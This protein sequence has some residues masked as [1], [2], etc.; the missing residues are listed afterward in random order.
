MLSELPPTDC[1]IGDERNV[2]EFGL[3][4]PSEDPRLIYQFWEKVPRAE[5]CATKTAVQS[6]GQLAGL[7]KKVNNERL[8]TVE[9][10]EEDDEDTQPAEA[11]R[12]KEAGK[13]G[14]RK[15][16]WL[17]R[18][19]GETIA[20]SEDDK[21][22]TTDQ[23]APSRKE[24]YKKEY[25]SAASGG[26]E[27][28]PMSKQSPKT[29]SPKLQSPQAPPPPDA[30]K[31][32]RPSAAKAPK[33]A[34]ERSHD[35]STP[36]GYDYQKKAKKDALPSTT[37]KEL[38]RSPVQL[39]PQHPPPARKAVL[40]SRHSPPRP[41]P[42]ARVVLTPNCRP[43]YPPPSRA[44]LR[45]ATPLWDRLRHELEALSET[46]RN[47][48]LIKFIKETCFN[49]TNCYRDR[50]GRKLKR[51]IPIPVKM[52]NLLETAQQ[53]RTSILQRYGYSDEAEIQETH[54]HTMLQ[55]ASSH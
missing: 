27:A 4:P 46:D 14:W 15:I 28:T 9:K 11:A 39:L 35:D 20:C 3:T 7:G 22:P 55:R 5:P 23:P 24:N 6:D 29:A 2:T 47:G 49:D 40:K 32:R 1:S 38:S 52:E 54:M 13:I 25:K 45:E 19:A 17:F 50:Y 51:P 31:M 48:S 41:P 42:Q 44:E 34:E 26:C 12:S 8:V 43:P 30:K 21:Q 37:K 36:S 16:R 33:C 18:N 10:P 53:K